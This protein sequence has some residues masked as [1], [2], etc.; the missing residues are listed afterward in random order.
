[1]Y[2]TPQCPFRASGCLNS[3]SSARGPGFR[4]PAKSPLVGPCLWVSETQNASADQPGVGVC[5]PRKR[6]TSRRGSTRYAGGRHGRETKVAPLSVVTRPELGSKS[7]ES[8]PGRQRRLWPAK[9]VARRGIRE[10]GRALDAGQ[11]GRK[12]S[13]ARYPQ[14]ADARSKNASL[15]EAVGRCAPA[16]SDRDAELRSF[17]HLSG[18]ARSF[19]FNNRR[20]GDGGFQSPQRR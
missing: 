14:H 15:C 17:G 11:A 16:R 20:V 5:R 9:R 12:G 2:G 6:K 3:A 8:R 13:R 10:C 19:G 7:R 18:T 1:M 4:D